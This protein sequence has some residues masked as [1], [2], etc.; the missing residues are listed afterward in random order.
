MVAEGMQVLAAISPPLKSRIEGG[1][2]RIQFFRGKSAIVD[3]APG[4]VA[5]RWPSGAT[6]LKTKDPYAREVMMILMLTAMLRESIQQQFALQVQQALVWR[7]VGGAP[8]RFVPGTPAEINR[9]KYQLLAPAPGLDLSPKNLVEQAWVDADLLRLFEVLQHARLT[10]RTIKS[11]LKA[12]GD[13]RERAA[14]SAASVQALIP[15]IPLLETLCEA[16]DLH[17]AGA[18]APSH[19]P[20]DLH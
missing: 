4:V 12:S 19:F 5:T 7:H 20:G 8:D 11:V 17:I 13:F 1:I 2:G 10:P 16:L 18:D 15:Q 6:P 3:N 9:A 14:R